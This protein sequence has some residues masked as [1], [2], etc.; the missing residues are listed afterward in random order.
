MSI[1]K[2]LSELEAS[3]PPMV[4]RFQS[5][6]KSVAK[7]RLYLAGTAIGD[8]NN[9]QSATNLLGL[10]GYISASM[11]R[12]VTGGRV[13][14]DKTRGRFLD[15]LDPPPHEVWEIRVTEPTINAR[16]FGRMCERDT[17]VITNFRTRQLLG[18][19]G[20]ADWAAAMESCVSQWGQLG[21]PLLVGSKIGDYVSENYDEFPI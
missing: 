14:G 1:Q 19:R 3:N 11:T 8:F 5:P 6:S 18:K 17:L 9:H 12:W 13:H 2:I 20:S 16:L 4:Q 10:K 21:L 7:R 15:R